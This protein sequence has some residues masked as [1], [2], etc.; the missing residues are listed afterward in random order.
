MI[1]FTNT[2]WKTKQHSYRCSP[3]QELIRFFIKQNGHCLLSECKKQ[4]WTNERDAH[5]A[6]F[7]FYIIYLAKVLGIDFNSAVFNL[8]YQMIQ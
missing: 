2:I 4:G 6:V 5:C 1:L 8:Y 7:R 3:P